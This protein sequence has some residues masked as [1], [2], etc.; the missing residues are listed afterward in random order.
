LLGVTGMELPTGI[1]AV[2]PAEQAY[3]PR[4]LLA[5]DDE[6]FRRLL[7][8]TLE[9][10][11]YSVT[12]VTT[13]AALLAA[14]QAVFRGDEPPALVV[15]DERM[16]GARGLAALQ[17][18]RDW[19]WTLPLVLITAFGDDELVG[20]AEKLGVRVMHKPFPIAELRALVRELAPRYGSGVVP[21]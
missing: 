15:S 18:A 4:V 16:P 10:D 3:R 12:G 2:T 13:G 9:E 5:E 11:G 14:L 1:V 17:Q 7:T 19:G 8:T 6:D 21:A 20:Q